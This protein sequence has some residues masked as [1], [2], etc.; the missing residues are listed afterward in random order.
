MWDRRWDKC[1]WIEH[2]NID[3]AASPSGWRVD[4]P[5]ADCAGIGGQLLGCRVTIRVHSAAR[6]VGRCTGGEV[7]CGPVVNHD[8]E[9]RHFRC[10]R[11][12]LLKVG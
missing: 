2:R 4:R 5:D 1:C 3:P 8:R 6:I 12:R 7:E 10:R 11:A 9:S